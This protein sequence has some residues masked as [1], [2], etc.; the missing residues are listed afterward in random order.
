MTELKS[1]T[2]HILL[3]DID[4]KTCDASPTKK[5]HYF[6]VSTQPKLATCLCSKYHTNFTS[7]FYKIS[8]QTILRTA[9]ME[10][11]PIISAKC[12]NRIT[13]ELQMSPTLKQQQ[14]QPTA[15]P[16]ILFSNF[17]TNP[18]PSKITPHS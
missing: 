9:P 3:A 18:T 16:K 4:P 8:L 13:D 11:S 12:F 2:L 1:G 10:T 14:Q 7:Q 17:N 15:N 5:Y 6:K